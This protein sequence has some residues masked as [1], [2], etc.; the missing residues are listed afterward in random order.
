MDWEKA[1]ARLDEVLQ[2]YKALI[3]RLG[4]NTSFA[5]MLTFDP[6]LK[7]YN[8]GERTQELYDAMLAVE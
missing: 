7:R 8:S 6:L 5:I 3:G 2:E 4:V 1:K